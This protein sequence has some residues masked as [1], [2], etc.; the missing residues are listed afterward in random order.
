MGAIELHA[1]INTAAKWATDRIHAGHEIGPIWHAV[2]AN[3]N[4]M[5]IPS[6]HEDKDITTILVRAIFELQHVVRCVFIDEAWI[7]KGD[8]ELDDHVHEHGRI[9][10]YADR[11][12][13]VFFTGEDNAAHISAYC[14]ITTGVNGKRHVG[15]LELMQFTTAEGRLVGMLPRGNAKVQ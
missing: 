6:P 5:I 8:K 12:D 2:T 11:Q 4:D 7:A 1:M 9:S 14:V 15:P 13:V 3:G 10:N